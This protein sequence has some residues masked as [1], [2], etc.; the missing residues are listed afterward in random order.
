MQQF[1]QFNTLFPILN[2]NQTI[3]TKTLI[4]KIHLTSNHLNKFKNLYIQNLNL[5][6]I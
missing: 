1:Q 6:K 2:E 5:H 3:K 4:N